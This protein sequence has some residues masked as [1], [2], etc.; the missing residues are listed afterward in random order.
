M[1]EPGHWRHFVWLAGILV[2]ASTGGYSGA[3]EAMNRQEPSPVF[4]IFGGT[5]SMALA[6]TALLS[7]RFSRS[8]KVQALLLTAVLY[9]L[10][11]CVLYALA[12]SGK[13]EFGSG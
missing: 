13:M 8:G 11:G 3:C 2:A 1:E 12:A 10:A 7:A 6:F 4:M 5:I 9:G